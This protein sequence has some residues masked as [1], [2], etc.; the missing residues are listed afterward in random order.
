MPCPLRGVERHLKFF[1]DEVLQVFQDTCQRLLDAQ[2]RIAQLED[3]LA[4]Q[5]EA[6]F[7][8][9]KTC[10]RRPR[11]RPGKKDQDAGASSGPFLACCSFS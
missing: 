5:V 1:G 7:F 10:P 9:Q 4:G 8:G 11:K 6:V 2:R 3:D